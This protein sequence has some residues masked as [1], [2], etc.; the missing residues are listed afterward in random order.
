M[1]T[2]KPFFTRL[3]LWIASLLIIPGSVYFYLLTGVHWEGGVTTRFYPV[4]FLL[5]IPLWGL[6]LLCGSVSSLKKSKTGTL[7]ATMPKSEKI[8]WSISSLVAFLSVPFVGL[9]LVFGW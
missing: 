4:L 5:A 7:P 1:T 9:Y 8:F 2:N 3:G 6:V